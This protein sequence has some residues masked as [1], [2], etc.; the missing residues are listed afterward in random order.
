[1]LHKSWECERTSFCFQS[2]NVNELHFVFRVL[3]VLFGSDKLTGATENI[4]T[5]GHSKNEKCPGNVELLLFI[6][7]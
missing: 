7:C 6:H 5:D 2:G 1:M 3:I 4:A